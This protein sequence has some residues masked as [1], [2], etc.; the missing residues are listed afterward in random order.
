MAKPTEIPTWATD[1]G[2]TSDPGPTHKARGFQPGKRCPAGWLNWVLSKQ[3]AWLN[4]LANLH[5]ES[6]F[7]NKVYSWTNSHYF[8]AGIATQG[9]LISHATNEYDYAAPRTR[10]ISVN[11]SRGLGSWRT[12][13]G[14]HSPAVTFVNESV[15]AYPIDLP[16]GATITA[17]QVG[18][19]QGFPSHVA[20]KDLRAR[21]K[22]YTAQPDGSVSI[23]SLSDVTPRSPGDTPN[24]KVTSLA[25]L[26]DAGVDNA[27]SWLELEV[28][29]SDS[30]NDHPAGI[31][32]V[33]DAVGWIQV[34]FTDPGPRNY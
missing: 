10:A 25:N 33:G 1:P 5:D 3:G 8:A 11:P 34:T 29:A 32:Y 24:F 7:L 21:L 14:E 4:Y 9:I 18:L 19:K 26:H 16:T 12:L 20:G 17:V 23:A 13:S 30:A 22:R 15:E 6:E 27:T 2:A 31:G 28:T